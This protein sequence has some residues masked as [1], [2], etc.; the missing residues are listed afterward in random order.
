[1][2]SKK[3]STLLWKVVRMV[4]RWRLVAFRMSQNPSSDD[5]ALSLGLNS[6]RDPL[7]IPDSQEEAV[8]GRS[9]RW[10]FWWSGGERWH[11][12]AQESETQYHAGGEKEDQGRHCWSA[13]QNHS[14]DWKTCTTNQRIP[15]E[16][17][18]SV[19]GWWIPALASSSFPCAWRQAWRGILWNRRDWHHLLIGPIECSSLQRGE[20]PQTE[21]WLEQEVSQGSTGRQGLHVISQW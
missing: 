17:P 20:Y 12:R 7:W 3:T 15:I 13:V 9:F 21:A 18:A 5:D 14:Q 8:S 4:N 1:M 19:Q 2:I 16:G 10:S 6:T 11:P